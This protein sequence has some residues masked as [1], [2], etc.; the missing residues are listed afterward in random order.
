MSKIEEKTCQNP[1]VKVGTLTSSERRSCQNCKKDFTI[2]PDDFAFYDR[3]K[4]PPPTFCF[5]C[6]LQRK[7]SWR[8]ERTLYKAKC[9]ATGKDMISMFDPVNNLTVYHRDYWWGDD[10]DQLAAGQD[11]D[12]SKP[13]FV[14]FRELLERAPLP[15]LAN[16]NVVNSE[17]GNHNADMKNCYLT[18]ASYNNENLSY[19][20]GGN[21]CK[22]SYDLYVAEKVDQA[23]ELTLVGHSSRSSFCYNCENCLDSHFLYA[24]ENLTNCLGC[25]NL[26]KK[27]YHIFNQPYTKEDYKKKLEALD[28]SSYKNLQAFKKQYY[29]FMKNYPRRYANIVKA[30]DSTGDMIVNAKNVKY[31]FDIYDDAQNCKYVLLGLGMKDCYD[32]FGLG[33]GAELMY[34]IVDTGLSASNIKFSCCA[35]G[36][37]NVEYIYGCHFSD[38]LFG[39]VGLRKNKYCIL[40]KQY[41]KE[42]Y[43]KLVQEI[44]KHMEDMPYMDKAG[45]VYEYGEYFPQELSPFTYN[46]TIA[47]KYY[48]LTEEEAEKSKFTWK[49]LQEKNYNVTVKS[50]DL[51]DHIK[52]VKDDILK[53]TIGCANNSDAQRGQSPDRKASGC[54]TDF[55]I[56]PNELEFYRKFNY[57]L[58][59]LCP[60]C[61]HYQRLAQ[62]NPFRLRAGKCM[63]AGTKSDSSKYQNLGLHFHGNDH[64]PNEFET[65]FTPESPETLYCG[66][67]YQEEIA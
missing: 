63:C 22:D 34:E 2:E 50:E 10:W 37:N 5:I 53:E 43:E 61:R 44:K 29:E 13:F 20:Y 57:P 23:Y 38:Y 66:T 32:G 35:H 30:Q 33:G 26:K 36:N 59:R 56:I 48:P 24:C 40:N 65:A 55:K 16:T 6:R 62:R 7:M 18:Y 64:C 27:S 42:E 39:C 51:P 31:S 41:T 8:N 25:I 1:D 15:N 60:N 11:Y 28:L 4:V 9:A 3:M 21:N 45:R 17:Y 12:F 14:Q 54:T 67:C 52:N 49:E 47:Q 19:S 46:E 58:P